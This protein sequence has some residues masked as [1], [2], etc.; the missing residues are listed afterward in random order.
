MLKD[1]ITNQD[2]KIIFSGINGK[3]DRGLKEEYLRRLFKE[4]DSSEI[5]EKTKAKIDEQII[6]TWDYVISKDV[7]RKMFFESE[8]SKNNKEKKEKI[9]IAISEWKKMGFGELKWPFAAGDIDNQVHRLNRRDDISGEEKDIILSDAIIRFRRVKEINQLKNDY[10]EYLVIKNND[11]VIPTFGNKRGTDFYIDGV[12]FDQKVSK[13]VGGDFKE[14]YG[15]DY[16]SVAINHPELLAQSLYEHQDPDRF[17]AEP[18]FLVVYLDT[19]MDSDE[20]E[21][22]LKGIDFSVPMSF[23]FEYGE[24]NGVKSVFHT[25]CYLILLHR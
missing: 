11:N 2:I 18:R 13:S 25:S 19:D 6:R 3:E 16:R 22:L 10:I 4:T 12:P 24:K 17:G 14:K 8:K 9:D 20:I 1:N 5:L 23:D 15:D 7:L 21:G